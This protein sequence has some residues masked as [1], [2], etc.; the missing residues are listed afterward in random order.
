M[1]HQCHFDGLDCCLH[2]SLVNNGICNQENLNFACAFDGNDCAYC[3]ATIPDR[4]RCCNS[5]RPCILG[6]GDCG[7]DDNH[8][9]NGL[10]CGSNNCEDEYSGKPFNCCT[11]KDTSLADLS[12][13][14]PN[15]SSIG[16]GLCNSENNNAIC[17]Y[18]GGD[19]CPNIDLIGNEQCDYVN[20]NHVCLFDGGDCCYRYSWETEI[21]NGQCNDIHNL[22]MCSYDQGDCCFNSKIGDGICDDTNNN[23]VC[24]YDG[25]DC[26]FGNIDTSR[27]TFCTCIQVFDVI[28]D[29]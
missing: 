21:G 16:N 11:L 26:C 15:Q 10:M 12:D 5:S 4:A 29:I 8:C 7:S 28:S 1:N 6:Q 27:C 2:A 9:A 18:D 17:N 25:G 19:C 24:H 20:Y 13:P 14:C 22:E 23:R 3:N